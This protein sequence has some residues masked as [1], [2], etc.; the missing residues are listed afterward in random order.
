MP[1]YGTKLTL[2]LV[3]L[4]LKEHRI[5]GIPLQR[6]QAPGRTWICGCFHV[7]VH[8]REPFHRRAPCA[9]AITCPAGTIVF[10]GDFKV[11]FTPHRRRGH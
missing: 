2:A 9:I 1:L 3:D 8:P 11:D 6:R 7:E 4:K 5:A 10:S